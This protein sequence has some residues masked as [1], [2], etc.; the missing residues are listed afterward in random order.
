[1]EPVQAGGNLGQFKPLPWVF[2]FSI[3]PM[4]A[5]KPMT[6]ST[7]SSHDPLLKETVD[8][9]VQKKRNV[10]QSVVLMCFITSVVYAFISHM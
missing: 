9:R 10:M 4:Y 6:T 8:L 3:D 7:S 2:F 5:F 1:M